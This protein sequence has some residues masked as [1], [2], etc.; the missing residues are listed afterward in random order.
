[1][2]AMRYHSNPMITMRR[3][4]RYGAVAVI[5][6][7]AIGGCDNGLTGVNDNPNSPTAVDARYLLPNAITGGVGLTLGTN[8]HMDITAL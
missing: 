1:M 3:S 4:I 5:A 8:L 7:L 2:T 6:L